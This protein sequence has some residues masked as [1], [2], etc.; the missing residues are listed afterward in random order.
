[1]MTDG[2]EGS[3]I[4]IVFVTQRYMKK[5]HGEGE[6]GE[7]DNCKFE[8][9]YAA[10][11]QGCRGNVPGRDGAAASTQII[12]RVSS[13]ASSAASSTPTS[14]RMRIWTLPSTRS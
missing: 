6:K 5:V 8:F 1:M 2:I 7:D 10:T 9:D 4:V 12:G 13:A 3:D 11:P 14:Q